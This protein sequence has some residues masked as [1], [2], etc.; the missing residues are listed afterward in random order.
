MSRVFLG[1][2]DTARARFS[3]FLAKASFVCIS[4]ACFPSVA[5]LISLARVFKRPCDSRRGSF[6][7]SPTEAVLLLRVRQLAELF[8]ERLPEEHVIRVIQQIVIAGNM[9][10]GPG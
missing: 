5:I 10:N 4:F 6:R 7:S 2:L 1:L 9:P 3:Y 8:G